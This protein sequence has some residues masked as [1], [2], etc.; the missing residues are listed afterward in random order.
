MATQ[1]SFAAD[2]AELGIT[3][4]AIAKLQ[5]AL[6]P[7]EASANRTPAATEGELISRGDGATLSEGRGTSVRGARS[8][9]S[10][11][12]AALDVVTT[13]DVVSA[14]SGTGLGDNELAPTR[15]GWSHTHI[16][17][18][19]PAVAPPPKTKGPALLAYLR[20]EGKGH[21]A[22]PGRP[23]D[24]GFNLDSGTLDPN[25]RGWRGGQHR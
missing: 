14:A 20:R 8:T 17:H 16:N 22:D 2:L 4:G 12:D 21:Y 19:G 3:E 24:G 1:A 6:S 15:S 9:L 11:V 18:V 25:H 13:T 7:T 5:S 10:V 23:A